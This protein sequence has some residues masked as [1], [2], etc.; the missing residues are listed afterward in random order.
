MET[1]NSQ[2]IQ[3]IIREMSMFNEIQYLS[4]SSSSSQLSSNNDAKNEALIINQGDI[5]EKIFIIS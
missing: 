5:N 4:S 2:M 1:D 3:N